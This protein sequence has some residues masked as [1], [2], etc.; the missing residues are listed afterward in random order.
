MLRDE[1]VEVTPTWAPDATTVGFREIDRQLRSIAKRRAGLDVEEARWLREAEKERIWRKLG[2]S[3]VLEY[4]EDVFGYAPRT[5]MERLRVAKELGELRGLEEEL[6]HGRLSWS[7]AKELS[8]VMTPATEAAW[9]ARARGKNL[10]DIEELV[11][12]RKKG[13]DPDAKQDPDLMTRKLVVELPQ[14]IDALVQQCR[15]AA[16]DE[17]G[18]HIDDAHLIEMLCRCFLLQPTAASGKPAPPA[19]RIVIHRCDDCAR[20]WQEGRG[21]RVQ[22]EPDDL[23]LAECDADMVDEESTTTKS[24]PQPVRK[25]VWARDRG[26]CRVPGC[27]ATRNLDIHHLV[28][29]A[30]G[31]DH[32]PSNLLVLCSGHHKLLHSGQLSITGLAPD[33]LHF[34]RDGK[35]LPTNAAAVTSQSPSAPNVDRRDAISEANR[36]RRSS[37]NRFGEVVTFEQAKRA[38]VDLG[39]KGRAAHQAL[40]EARAHVGG[41]ASVT[42]LVK[43]VIV[44]GA[45][46]PNDSDNIKLAS[47]ALD[48]LGYATTIARSAV[49]VASAH[50][51]ATADLETLIREALRRCISMA[52]TT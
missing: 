24:I 51:G 34:V 4:L 3:T 33:Q 39:Y 49:K 19:H 29:R 26:R 6:C 41:D 35:P 21:R 27:R 13:D 52:S 30:H 36:P 7:A 18:H 38:L 20:A 1:S 25:Q 45:I 17:L 50:V 10:R 16:A 32:Q 2:F 48:R 11:A 15:A 44:H 14:R 31:G 9:L 43:A 23:R 22:I 8:R 40:L 42:E 37:A 47:T 12:G 28:H 5:A 46:D